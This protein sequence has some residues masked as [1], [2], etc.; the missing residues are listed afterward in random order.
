MDTCDQQLGY[1]ES[2][3]RSL[4]MHR[5]I[6]ERLRANPE[7]V[8]SVARENIRRWSAVRGAHQYSEWTGILDLGVE[9]VLEVL[10]AET[11]EGQRLRS[12]APFTGIL[13]H[14]ERNSFFVGKKKQVS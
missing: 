1:L 7:G 12:S 8:L 5:L 9:A 6:A 2:D 11:H 4:R 14:E 13:S 10:E 3:W